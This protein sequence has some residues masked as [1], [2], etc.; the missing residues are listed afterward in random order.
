LRR[1]G[2]I[3]ISMTQNRRQVF[4]D[5]KVTSGIATLSQKGRGKE[6]SFWEASDR[7]TS[8]GLHKN[9]SALRGSPLYTALKN[10]RTTLKKEK[11]IE[12]FKKAPGRKKKQRGEEGGGAH[13]REG[14]RE[15]A[16]R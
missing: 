16:S 10:T 2:R 7:E 3:E 8:L 1:K 11:G 9:P 5:E 4:P 14:S 12:D 6:T 15:D 13:T